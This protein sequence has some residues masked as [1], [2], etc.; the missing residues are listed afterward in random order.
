MAHHQQINLARRNGKGTNQFIAGKPINV[1]EV[2]N[3]LVEGSSSGR[4]PAV[5]RAANALLE[6]MA[7]YIWL[8]TAGPHQGGRGEDWTSHIT[9]KIMKTNASYHLRIDN[10]KHLFHITGGSLQNEV[11]PWL[12]PGQPTD[13]E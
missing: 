7:K 6:E 12:A 11:K 10:K 3:L 5:R 9:V 8:I 13:T 2:V 1:D 4:H